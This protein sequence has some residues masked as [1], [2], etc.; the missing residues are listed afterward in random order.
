MNAQKVSVV[1]LRTCY[2]TSV[3][4]VYQC[5]PFSVY[6]VTVKDWNWV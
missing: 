6:K 4:V 3:P 1:P 5:W 2:T